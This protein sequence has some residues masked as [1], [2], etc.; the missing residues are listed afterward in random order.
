VIQRAP[1][2]VKTV[3]VPSEPAATALAVVFAHDKIADVPGEAT[4]VGRGYV[5]HFSLDGKSVDKDKIPKVIHPVT[6][7]VVDLDKYNIIT[8]AMVADIM[9]G[10]PIRPIVT[11]S[12]AQTL[13]NIGEM[14]I[15]DAGGKLHVRN[16]ADDILQFRRYTVPKEEKTKKAKEDT[17]GGLEGAMPGG[18]PRRGAD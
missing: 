18:R 1:T 5:L 16:E 6:K 8:N 9:G 3:D 7:E 12:A 13:T 11:G 2:R 14:L 10:E 15:M 4:N 17:A